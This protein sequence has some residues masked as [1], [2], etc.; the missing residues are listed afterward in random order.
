MY[1]M[2]SEGYEIN[3]FLKVAN[4]T[5]CQAICQEEDEECNLKS[6]YEL[7]LCYI[8][9]QNSALTVSVPPPGVCLTVHSISDTCSSE[10]LFIKEIS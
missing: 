1:N 5:V 4:V 7:P 10:V 2:D 3:T 6:D 9:I 8:I